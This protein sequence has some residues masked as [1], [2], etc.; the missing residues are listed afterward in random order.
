[1]NKTP[2]S[3]HVV[4]TE[5]RYKGKVYRAHLL[6]RSVRKD[7]K[8]LKETLANLTPLGDDI[9]A[10]IR[11]ALAGEQLAPVESLF[12]VVRSPHHGHVDAVLT[13]MHHLGFES[14]LASKSSRLRTLAVAMVV[15]RILQPSSKLASTRWWHT[16]TLPDL[17]DVAD[18]NEDDLY[19]AMDWLLEQ[20]PRIEQKLAKRHLHDDGLALFDLSS[21]YFE[22]RT[23]PLAARGYNRDGKTGK[24]QIN[25][26]LLTDSLG[27]PVSVS[28]FEGNVGDTQTLLPQIQQLRKNFSINRFAIVGDRGMISQTQIDVLRTMDGVDWV[29][30]LRTEAVRKV[31]N[32]DALQP[33]LF[34]ERNLFEFT[35]PDFPG[36]RLIACR[37]PAL[38]ERRA[39]KR[40]SLIEA[41]IKEL[42]KVRSMVARGRLRGADTIGVRVGKVV[43]KYKVAKHIELAIQDDAFAFEINQARVRQEAALDGLYVIRTSLSDQHLDTDEA[44]R[45]YK[46]LTQVERAFRSLKTLDLHVRPIY[47][48]DA[49][50]VRAHILL[51]MLA[52]YVQ[53]HMMVAWRPLLFADED[54][55]AKR[56]RNPVAPAQRSASAARKAATKKTAGGAPVHSFRTL[57]QSLSTITR[58]HCRRQGG[59]DDEPLFTLHTTPDAAQHIWDSGADRHCDCSCRRTPCRSPPPRCRTSA[60]PGAPTRG[61]SPRFRRPTRW[62]CFRLEGYC[63]DATSRPIGASLSGSPASRKSLPAPGPSD[64]PALSQWKPEETERS[65]KE[66]HAS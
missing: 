46:R 3:A 11:Q 61:C 14:L 56:S 4:T 53:W 17:L 57:L 45:S 55:Q 66:S 64:L 41:T 2:L 25:F 6:R 33:D 47:H 7:G 21:T 10:L 58:N 27:C 54:Q 18:A 43:N 23:C 40:Q 32:D 62:G 8:V 5:R 13:A 48:R 31:V 59:N 36:E 29:T 35:H 28:V 1:M 50:R 12:E 51:C 38:A 44:V 22:G 19:E 9:V 20:Q 49:N 39:S 42:D 52:Y 24:L 37:N 34:D 16:T 15:A 26:G 65:R 60:I 30:A 63:C